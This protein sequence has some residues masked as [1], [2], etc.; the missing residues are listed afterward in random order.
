MENKVLLTGLALLAAMC[1]GTSA[2]SL[3]GA[4]LKHNN[5]EVSL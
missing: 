2:M 1:V 3:P 5:M 4:D